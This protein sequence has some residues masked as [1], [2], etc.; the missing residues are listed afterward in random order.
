[1]QPSHPVVRPLTLLLLCAAVVL[2]NDNFDDDD[3]DELDSSD[4]LSQRQKVKRA[5]E[6]HEESSVS[7]L[8]E[9]KLH[10]Y[11]REEPPSLDKTTVV[12]LGIYIIS[13]YSINEQTMDYMVSMYLR[14]A[15][16]DPRLK[17]EPPAKIRSREKLASIRLG[18]KSWDK[19][20]IPDTFLRNEK[21]ADF[22][23]VTVENRMLKLSE[24]GDLWYVTKI[25]ATLSCPMMLK[26]FPLDTQTCPML[27]ESFGYTMD[28]MSFGKLDNPVDVSDDLQ[29]PQFKMIGEDV[30]DCSQN[31]TTGAYPCLEFQFFLRRDIGY[32]LI[33]VYVP[34]ILIVILSWVSFWINVDASPARVS[35]GLLT[36]LTTTTMSGSARSSLPRVSYIKAIDIW[37]IICLLFVFT[38]LIEY[39]IVNTLARRVNRP[40]K[41]GCPTAARA[42]GPA[43]GLPRRDPE[44]GTP[45]QP[46]GRRKAP[47]SLSGCFKVNVGDNRATASGTRL[48][49]GQVLAAAGPPTAA[50]APAM[51]PVDGKLQARRVDKISRK[52]FPTAFTVFNIVYWAVYVEPWSAALNASRNPK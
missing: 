20:W 41:R 45:L 21:G 40:A 10:N 48:T 3:G 12:K 19:I 24:N 27:F 26:N 42:A 11:N 52:V 30:N 8:F 22:H 37:M 35:I 17:F 25:S 44:L 29:M 51:E 5:P 43:G 18:D 33:Q 6:Q 28:T 4:V 9:K 46:L 15:W 2:A 13:F 31:Y 36:V 38:S 39:A 1:M 16:N 23:E 34:S 49:V 32:F 7:K 50:A 47:N 14:Q